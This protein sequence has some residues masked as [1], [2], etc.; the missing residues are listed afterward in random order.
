MASKMH[1]QTPLRL[2]RL[3]HR[4]TLFQPPNTAGKSR[5]GEPVRTIQHAHDCL[6]NSLESNFNENENPNSPHN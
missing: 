4:K 3:N 2:H 5:H 6:K 1:H